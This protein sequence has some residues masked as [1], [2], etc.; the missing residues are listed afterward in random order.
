ME[1]TITSIKEIRIT[2]CKKCGNIISIIGRE[3]LTQDIMCNCYC[4]TTFTNL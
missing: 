4:K 2:Y 1:K 3:I